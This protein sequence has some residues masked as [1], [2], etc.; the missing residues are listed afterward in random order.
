M[1]QMWQTAATDG[2]I[3][4]L[5]ELMNQ[6]QWELLGVSVC[7]DTEAWKYFI[8]V[9]SNKDLDGQPGSVHGSDFHLGD[10]LRQRNKPVHSRIGAT[11]CHRVASQLPGMNTALPQTL[12]FISMLIR[13]MPSMKF[14]YRLL[15]NNQT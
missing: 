13:K 11:N 14:G 4:K 7:N 9:A 6:Q 1:P 8:A 12:R 5:A 3:E 15:K 2:T 10:L